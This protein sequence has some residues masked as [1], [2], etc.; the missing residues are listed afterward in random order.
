MLIRNSRRGSIG[1]YIPSNICTRLLCSEFIPQS[2]RSECTTLVRN[3][4]SGPCGLTD[5]IQ[6]F[7]PASEVYYLHC[8]AQAAH[9][10]NTWHRDLSIID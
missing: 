10:A 5:P 9:M 8:E 3:A 1:A 7:I 4:E 6:S 2:H